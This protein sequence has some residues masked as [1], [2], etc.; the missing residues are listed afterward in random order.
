[1]S[2]PEGLT[3]DQATGNVYV[4]DKAFFRVQVFTSQGVF[5]RSF[6]QDVVNGAG[7]ENKPAQPEKQTLTVDA[8]A[9]QYKLT[10]QGQTTADLD[11]D[12]SAATV[13]TAL[14]SLSS[15][16][17]ANATV[18]GGPGGS[19]P[20]VISFAGALNNSPQP[21]IASSNGT[22]PLSG[23]TATASVV[24]TQAGSSGFEI[25]NV[26][27]NC[28]TGAAGA[29]AGALPNGG[30]NG[31]SGIAV[32]PAGTPNAGNLLVANPGNIRV[33]EYTSTGSFVRAFGWDVVSAGP[34]NT[35]TAFEVCEASRFDV[36]KVGVQGAGSG[37][38]GRSGLA[39]T[40]SPNRIVESPAGVIYTVE[41]GTNFRVQKF[42][43]PS[44]IITPQGVFLASALSGTSLAASSPRDI[45][46]DGDGNLYLSKLQPVGA[47]L[48]P[49]EPSPPAF[50]PEPRVLKIDPGANAGAG[51][52]VDEYL[53]NPGIVG[54]FTIAGLIGLA[55]SEDGFPVYAISNSPVRIYK[56]GVVLGLT[57]EFEAPTELGATAATL[58]VKVTP[59]TIPL[60][61]SF[62]VEY[63]T[64]E[65][66]IANGNSFSGPNAP[67]VT[68]IPDGPL[69]N[70]S[71]GGEA[72]SCPS[73][74]AATC[75]IAI[76]IL[77]LEPGAAYKVRLRAA[78]VY[79]GDV[80][81]IVQTLSVPPA[82]APVPV[83]GG[84]RWSSPAS[85]EP[86]LL[87]AGVVNP[88][89]QRATYSFQYV[90]DHTYQEGLGSGDGFQQAKQS[91]VIAGEAGRGGND[92]YVRQT[93]FGLDPTVAYRFRLVATNA[94]GTALGAI[95]T[96][97]PPSSTD[98][99]YEWGSIGESWGSGINQE[100]GSLADDGVTVQ[101][102]AQA[103]GQPSSLP[104]TSSPFVAHR[105][106]AGWEVRWALQDPSHANRG[107]YA[108]ERNLS[109][110]LQRALWTESS[111][112]ERQRGEAQMVIT[113]LD[114]SRTV[115][116]PRVVPIQ[117][118]GGEGEYN[119]MGAAEN[120]ETFVFAY[121]STSGAVKLFPD[122]KLLP[123]GR[124]N[125]YAVT[126]AG[127]PSPTLAL[128]NRAD[129][130]SGPV[131]GGSCGAGIGST[132]GNAGG[133][134]SHAVSNDGMVVYFTVRPDAPSEGGCTEAGNGRR[135]FKRV[136][137]SQTVELSACGK[138]LPGT[139]T[140]TGSDE[141]QGA[142]SD[143]SIGFFTTSR[144]LVDGDTD[145]ASDLYVYDSNLPVAQR[146]AQASA[147]ETVPGHVA[148]TGAG[149]LGVLDNSADGSRVY[150][151]ATG[152]LTGANER[153]A[154]PALGNPNLYVYERD[155][156]HSGGRIAYVGGLV[157][158]IAQDEFQ[159]LNGEDARKNAVALPAS[160]S[161]ADGHVL[162]FTTSSALTADDGD[163][164]KD[165][166]RY[167]D[168]SSD[169]AALLRCVSCAGDG[170]SDVKSFARWVG[171]SKPDVV[172][173]ARVAS[174]DLE[175]FV[176]V[177]KEQL[178][179]GDEN[180]AW[181]VYSWNDGSIQLITGGTERFGVVVEETSDTTSTTA[182]SPDGSN[183][184]FVTS[185]PLDSA[186]TNSAPDLYNARV[187]GGFPASPPD[188][189]E[190][191]GQDSCYGSLPPAPIPP[192][193]GSST[194]AGPGNEV[195]P[196]AC[197]K[198]KVRKNGKCVNK[199]PAKCG[200]GKVRKKGKC[201][202]KNQRAERGRR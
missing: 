1:M 56:L 35:G 22:T 89:G 90:D 85:T 146:L 157:S 6:G 107:T 48:I 106:S 167:D 116:S 69:G 132:F 9:G 115:A 20:L 154:A 27:A 193:S 141:F 92:V 197:G 95:K 138:T 172:Q 140:E 38:F 160:G 161:E 87:L 168:T 14:Q 147:G 49:V 139:C 41:T 159:W 130:A 137:N 134:A 123:N 74:K 98:R 65:D 176:F 77:G 52:V 26:A 96:I 94:E 152:I 93:I 71:A 149:V 66:Y 17:A 151:V 51:A 144:Q 70:G 177:S 91:P 200:K 13:Q 2:G 117:R 170:P 112:G 16:G 164:A 8:T 28:K 11:F 122:E 166:Y 80:A 195:P 143:G 192:V 67:A 29:T 131:L 171:F 174:A 61:T 40:A 129:G 128:V 118:N 108:V 44:N 111:I 24:S 201:V 145:T 3:I 148:G 102:T 64:E 191:A 76:R 169:P 187:G 33:E 190:C 59:A 53:A 18:T 73:P 142:S 39:G 127:G 100:I 60:E 156:D 125:L 120:L 75:R 72:S 37:Q 34:G 185:A 110:D 54:P 184:Y 121:R 23:G 5:V 113:G 83:T 25:C 194:F 165:L 58:N 68:P 135:V 150:F 182:I 30:A 62:R 181:D 81:T 153:G 78:S 175:T 19:S 162:A 82:S 43:L 126:G 158:G 119:I 155:A 199:K 101:F 105:D 97:V 173:T 124:A 86:T 84:G 99:F 46:V 79:N 202:K 186:D 42:T 178:T 57:A 163:S 114:G 47:G 196:P 183:I 136:N 189:S 12:A 32:A 55:V 50:P 45:G 109:T 198:G 15:V 103:F 63:L 133:I 36:C 7:G 21:L 188:G 179:P 88:S 31:G 180:Q 4:F 10:F 104:G